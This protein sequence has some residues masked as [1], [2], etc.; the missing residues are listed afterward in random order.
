MV[1]KEPSFR[2]LFCNNN[3]RERY[4]IRILYACCKI[5]ILDC[6]IKI[7][8]TRISLL[9]GAIKKALKMGGYILVVFTRCNS[10][11]NPVWVS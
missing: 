7:Q 11:Y 2:G 10:L 8:K 5:I 3:R 9:K 6:G 4:L 1:F